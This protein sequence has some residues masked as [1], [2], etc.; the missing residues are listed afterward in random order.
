MARR[1]NKKAAKAIVEITLGASIGQVADSYNVSTKTVK[2]WL[3][4]MTTDPELSRSVSEYAKVALGAQTVTWG[5]Q[6]ERTYS[7]AIEL[8]Y[9]QLM[10]VDS[11][12]EMTAFEKLRATT[13]VAS[14][15]GE[16]QIAREVLGGSQVIEQNAE[17]AAPSAGITPALSATTY[18]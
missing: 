9:K 8:L 11:D 6:L 15:L 18:N 2:R 17:I 10:Q 4:A 13:T 7:K 5:Q 12:P 3:D 1:N 14:V 16:M